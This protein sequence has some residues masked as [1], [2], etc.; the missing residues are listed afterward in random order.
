MSVVEG[1]SKLKVFVAA[2]ARAGRKLKFRLKSP[3]VI[4]EVS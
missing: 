1:V 4:V 2:S 3:I